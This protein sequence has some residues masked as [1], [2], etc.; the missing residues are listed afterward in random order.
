M[1]SNIHT[2]SLKCK[3]GL[4]LEHSTPLGK[5]FWCVF[6]IENGVIAP[7]KDTTLSQGFQ[8]TEM[9]IPLTFY[10]GFAPF[11]FLLI[12]TNSPVPAGGKHTHNMMLPPQKCQI[13]WHTEADLT[14]YLNVNDISML[15]YPSVNIIFMYIYYPLTVKYLNMHKRGDT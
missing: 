9:C 3:S 5:L 11:I 13:Q 1:D 2:V 15:L 14:R 12:L 10:L 4:R 7:L 8:K 6:C